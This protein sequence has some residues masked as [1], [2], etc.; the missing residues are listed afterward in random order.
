MPVYP[1]ETRPIYFSTAPFSLAQSA[2]AS[3]C[4]SS[5]WPR[6]C[7]GDMTALPISRSDPSVSYSC[8]TI[9]DVRISRNP[10]SGCLWKSLLHSISLL[11]SSFI[12]H[13]PLARSLFFK[14]NTHTWSKRQSREEENQQ[15]DDP[16]SKERQ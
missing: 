2:W 8:A 11:S 1:S 9:V 3:V 12:F 10:S 15:Q 16:R 4:A 14:I 5:G 6:Q 7:P 13:A